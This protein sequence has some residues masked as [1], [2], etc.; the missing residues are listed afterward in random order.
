MGRSQT[1]P[2]KTYF[3]YDPVEKKS[4]CKLCKIA[5]AR[6]QSSN[7]EKHIERLHKNVFKKL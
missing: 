4:T 5:L 1:N 7:Q 3:V 6:N 2:V